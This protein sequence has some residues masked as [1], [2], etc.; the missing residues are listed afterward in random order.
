[1]NESASQGEASCIPVGVPGL[2]VVLRGGL[3][4]ERLY[5]VQGSAGSGKTTLGLQFLLEGARRGEPVLLVSLLQTRDELQDI[6]SAHGWSLDDVRVLEIPLELHEA[7]EQEQTVFSPADVELHEITDAVI[8]SVREHR[9]QRMVLDSLSELQLIIDSP[10]QMRRQLMKLKRALL[11]V[12]CTSVL[13]AD[14]ALLEDQPVVQTIVHGVISLYREVPPYGEM[15][16]KLE[17][18]K[19]RGRDFSGGYHDFSIRT[20]GL[21]VFPRFTERTDREQTRELLP[22][23]NEELDAMLGGGLDRGSVCMLIGTPG[24]GKSTLTS[25]YVSQLA[26]RG[27][28]SVVYCFDESRRTYLSRAE[29]L[30]LDIVQHVD[31][32]NVS[33]REYSVGDLTPAQFM[34]DLRRDVEEHHAGLVVIDSFTGFLNLMPGHEQLIPKLHE[35]LRFLSGHGVVT[36]MTVSEHGALGTAG[37]EA[38]TSYLADAL[39]LVRHFEAFGSLRRCLSV[40]KRRHGRHE[41]TIREL[42]IVAGGVRVGEPLWHFTGLLS[43]TPR[44]EGP[45]EALLE[46]QQEGP[47]DGSGS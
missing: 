43:G 6:V 21:T 4:A 8:E 46:R 22:S 41:K 40:V 23:G 1:M 26:D 29:S 30:Q 14:D 36:L 19:V 32:G 15:R 44:F 39:L 13:T 18:E 33:L 42:E 3:P 16:R 31:G 20:G 37:A 38:P 35:V 17:V 28:F 25:L 27:E 10:H 5:L 45:P 2:D 9:P 11:S 7:A 34:Q 24:A 12:G 47:D